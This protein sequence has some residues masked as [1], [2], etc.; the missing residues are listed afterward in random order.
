MAP[1]PEAA[2]GSLDLSM[3]KCINYKCAA[4]FCSALLCCRS[5]LCCR[6]AVALSYLITVLSLARRRVRCFS[7]SLSASVFL[8]VLFQAV[9]YCRRCQTAPH[10]LQ[11]HGD[12]RAFHACLTSVHVVG[13]QPHASSPGS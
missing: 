2:Y 6:S 11:V 13:S 9:T 8:F 3:R 1:W 10:L 7:E 5:M 4:L 12:G